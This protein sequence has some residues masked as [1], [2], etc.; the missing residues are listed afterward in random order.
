[1]TAREAD[2]IKKRWQ[3]A[4]QRTNDILSA[5]GRVISVKPGEPVDYYSP[6][7]KVFVRVY[8]DALPDQIRRELESFK[9][10]VN[11]DRVY[12]HIYGPGDDKP[13]PVEIFPRVKS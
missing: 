10:D 9:K 3:R 6:V 8:L 13:K 4:H 7:I 1:M 11:G 5:W 12:A 2:A